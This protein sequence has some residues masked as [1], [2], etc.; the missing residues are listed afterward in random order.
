MGVAVVSAVS[1]WVIMPST[2]QFCAG[3][4][5]P[6]MDTMGNHHP[7][8]AC[9]SLQEGNQGLGK[10]MPLSLASRRWGYIDVQDKT[11]KQQLGPARTPQP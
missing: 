4:L 2:E 7:M 1:T 6:S 11:R 3:V 9:A 10:D 8:C 5:A